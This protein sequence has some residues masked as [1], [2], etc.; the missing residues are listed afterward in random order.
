[1]ERLAIESD[2]L[3]NEIKIPDWAELPSTVGH[4]KPR[5]KLPGPPGKAKY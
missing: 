2:S 1:M 4:G 3:V 5:R